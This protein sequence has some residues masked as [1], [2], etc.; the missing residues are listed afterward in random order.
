MDYSNG[1]DGA[2]EDGRTEL[3]SGNAKRRGRNY[4]T[5]GLRRK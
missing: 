2:T 5:Q 4:I 1:L 3:R